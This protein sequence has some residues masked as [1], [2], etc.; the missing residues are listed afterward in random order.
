MAQIIPELIE[1]ASIVIDS[2]AWRFERLDGNSGFARNENGK[3]IAFDAREVRVLGA[4]LLCLP[5][6]VESVTPPA[7]V[8]LDFATGEAASLTAL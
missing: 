6:R 1:G 2:K 8:T 5:G 7:T 3:Q 4:G